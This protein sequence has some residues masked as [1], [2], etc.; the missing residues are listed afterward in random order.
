MKLH[1]TD[2]PWMTAEI[3]DAIK[4]RQHAWVND[5][6]LQYKSYRNKVNSLCKQARRRFY[7]ESI[8][9]TRDTNPKKWWDNIKLLSGLSK[10]APLSSITADGSV[11]RD[12]ERVEAI[13][14]TFS[15]VANDIPPL[16]FTPIP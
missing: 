11:L 9:H 14:D 12:N 8:S 4:R 15:K 13:N 5:F 16:K 2:K 6:P 1:P 10:P 7:R 3:K